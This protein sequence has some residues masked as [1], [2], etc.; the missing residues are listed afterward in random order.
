MKGGKIDSV[1]TN[2]ES[3]LERTPQSRDVQSPSDLGGGGGG[4]NREPKE[5]EE[6]EEEEP[7]GDPRGG[8]RGRG[9][10]PKKCTR[11]GMVYGLAHS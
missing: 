9:S 3:Y 7:G 11:D 4:G 10:G 8:S 5:K 6:E 1:D 2:P